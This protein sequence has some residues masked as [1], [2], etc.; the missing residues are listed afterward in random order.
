MFNKITAEQRVIYSCNIQTSSPPTLL[1]LQLTSGKKYYFVLFP[2]P[3]GPLEVPRSSS[4]QEQ[5]RNI[6][7]NFNLYCTWI[8][9]FQC[10]SVSDSLFA[11]AQRDNVYK[12]LGQKMWNK[13]C[14]LMMK[15]DGRRY[16]NWELTMIHNSSLAYSTTTLSSRSA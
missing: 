10:R 13:V 8:F 11:F 16:L 4:F 14:L 3:M 2:T 1:H 7:F 5:T 9:Y 6:P 15:T 12:M